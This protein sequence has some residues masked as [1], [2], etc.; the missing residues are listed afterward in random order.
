MADATQSLAFAFGIGAL[1]A[2]VSA[3]LRIPAVLP[4]L[5]AGV[6]A[7]PAGLGIVDLASV[8]GLFR[9]IV[10]LSIGLLVFEGGL[11]LDRKE[12]GRAPRAVVGLLTLGATVTLGGSMAVGMR[13]LG[14]EWPIAL[15]FGALLVVTGPT[16]VQPILRAVRLSPRLRSVL[17]A[18]AILIDPI[19]V[20]CAVAAL[21]VALAY[22]RGAFG[23]SWPTILVGFGVPFLS[24]VGVGAAAGAL[25]LVVFR[26]L[27]A[28]LGPN[29]A[30]VGICMLAIGVGE[31]ITHE[32]GLVAA[33][34]AGVILSNLQVVKTSDLRRFKE[35]IATILVGML[36]VLL[37]SSFDVGA[38]EALGRREYLAA[39]LVLFAIRPLAVLLATARS[40][41]LWRERA[42]AALFAPRGVVAASVAALTVTELESVF[43][44]L[45]N[46]PALAEQLRLVNALIVLLIAGSVAWATIAAWP[47]GWL[48][49]VLGGAPSG[50]AIVG[51][52][53]LGRAVGR[54]LRQ[55]GVEVILLDSNAARVL[56]AS[57]CGLDAEVIDAT[58]T[59]ALAGALRERE[60]G[61][62][63]GWTGNA[64]VDRIVER[65]GRAAFG[66]GH[67]TMALPTPPGGS[68][69][70]A[71]AL[72][73]RPSVLRELDAACADGVLRPQ[74]AQ[75]GDSADAGIGAVLAL[76]DAVVVGF[77]D[78]AGSAKR[79][80]YLRLVRADD[81][82][83]KAPTGD[84]LPVPDAEAVEPSEPA[85][86]NGPDGH[87]R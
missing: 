64:D 79:T 75:A 39:A 82:S 18:E 20:L 41:L 19:G 16:V 84:A 72:S 37:A 46:G 26:V 23:G 45:P 12:L 65:W 10:A 58:D 11:H 61:W 38:L 44:P 85:T 69:A 60:I 9:A 47:L 14:L 56:S 31:R 67:A 22:Y 73:E 86:A 48:L 17:G 32:G 24:G 55:E 36:F 35:Q 25:G 34:V 15:L 81:A 29:V 63:L 3:R 53:G 51:A 49:G 50:V 43:A 71:H 7:G 8:A 70:R 83:A 78:Y 59:A 6:L 76:R 28:R 21:E 57:A 30:A 33:T 1:V 68:G 62:L 13:Q 2:S 87:A 5:V 74:F 40:R 27:G 42:F 80:R 4:L 77:A 54:A 66:D 52:H